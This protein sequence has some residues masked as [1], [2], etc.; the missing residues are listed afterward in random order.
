MLHSCHG[1]Y[2][3]PLVTNVVTFLTNYAETK[4]IHILC[5]GTF[6]SYLLNSCPFSLV[7]SSKNQSE[8]RT[9]SS[10]KTKLAN[11]F[12]SPATYAKYLP[13]DTV[14]QDCVKWKES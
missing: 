2:K 6:L 7:N 13:L 11:A 12:T 3:S 5:S 1:F 8:M 4:K 10:Y 14:V 9:G